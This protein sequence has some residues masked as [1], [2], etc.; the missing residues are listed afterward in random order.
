MKRKKR[1][2]EEK[3]EPVIAGGGGDGLHRGSSHVGRTALRAGVGRWGGS[4]QGRRKKSLE[5]SGEGRRGKAFVRKG[6]GPEHP[7]S[8]CGQPENLTFSFCGPHVEGL[9]PPNLI[10]YYREVSPRDA[11]SLLLT[12]RDAPAMFEINST[13]FTLT[14]Q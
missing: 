6:F 8:F 11:P 7:C 14:G 9:R 1:E 3:A 12:T 2:E 4:K 10:I 13:I 5:D